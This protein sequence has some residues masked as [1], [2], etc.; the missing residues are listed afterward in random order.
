MI[1]KRSLV[2]ALPLL[3]V[4]TLAALLQIPAAT[5]GNATEAEVTPDPLNRPAAGTANLV[6]T[7][8]YL[9]P[10]N[11]ATVQQW[12]RKLGGSL[13]RAIGGRLHPAGISLR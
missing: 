1:K 8:S 11:Y 7:Q 2:F 6:S 10:T 12:R 5:G 13:S 3:A 9:T 4:L